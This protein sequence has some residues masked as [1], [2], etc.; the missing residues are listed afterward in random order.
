MFHTSSVYGYLQG[1]GRVQVKVVLNYAKK[2]KNTKE[3]NYHVLTSVLSK[4]IMV[5]LLRIYLYP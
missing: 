4:V 5:T 3:K 2:K 1:A